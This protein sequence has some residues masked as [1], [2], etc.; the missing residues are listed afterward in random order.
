MR[1]GGWLVVEREGNK[2]G[3]VGEGGKQEETD[4]V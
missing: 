1:G 3:G 2:R 4:V